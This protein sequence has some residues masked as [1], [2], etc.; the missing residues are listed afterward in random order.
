MT[1]C[2]RKIGIPANMTNDQIVKGE[3]SSRLG[4]LEK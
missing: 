4:R 3:Q 1:V 2:C